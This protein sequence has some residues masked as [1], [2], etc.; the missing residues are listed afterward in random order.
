MNDLGRL[1]AKMVVFRGL[2]LRG[3]SEFRYRWR[4][5]GRQ[6][7]RI[8]VLARDS[9]FRSSVILRRGTSDVPVFEQVLVSADYNLRRLERW[10]EILESYPWRA[11]VPP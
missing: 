5:A 3:P 1:L 11:T 8:D 7:Y 6:F 9:P 4:R 10:P 2:P